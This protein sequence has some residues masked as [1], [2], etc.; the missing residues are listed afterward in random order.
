MEET[1]HKEIAMGY[2]T[3][4]HMFASYRELTPA[5]LRERGVDVL[6]MDID[7]T[8]APYE[9]P[10]PDESIKAWIGEMQAAGIGFFFLSYIKYIKEEKS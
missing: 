6:I 4:D 5:Y 3:P 9:Q 10:E 1:C 8:L 7:N 2:L